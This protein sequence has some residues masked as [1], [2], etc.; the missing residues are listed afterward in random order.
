MPAEPA[1]RTDPQPHADEAL[2]L[3]TWSPW[4]G[5]TEKNLAELQAM[6]VTSPGGLHDVLAG[7]RARQQR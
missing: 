2:R 4:I 1:V 6:L 3:E 5:E 7:Q